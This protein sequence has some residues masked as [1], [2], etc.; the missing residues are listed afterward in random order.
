MKFILRFLVIVLLGYFLPFYLP[1]WSLMIIC[2]LVGFVV[3]GNHFLVFNA[4]FLGG[5]LVWLGL[6]FKLDIESQS[7]LSV[8][9]VQLGFPFED[10]TLLLILAGV[11]LTDRAERR[12]GATV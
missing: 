12:V 8:K 9:I 6:S 11:I 2:F 7:I 1:W 10:A 3:P 4:G 5:G